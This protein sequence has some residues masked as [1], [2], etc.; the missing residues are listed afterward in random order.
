MSVLK[1]AFGKEGL[2]EAPSR[3]VANVDEA[4]AAVGID[5]E[6]RVLEIW[7]SS[8]G[9]VFGAALKDSINPY[10][11]AADIVACANE[12]ARMVGLET[13]DEKEI[14]RRSAIEFDRAL[15]RSEESFRNPAVRPT[16]EKCSKPTAVI[17][18]GVRYCKAH[19]REHGVLPTGKI[20]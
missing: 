11:L 4:Q 20:T 3:S 18:D 6:G 7:F 12:M 13:L 10:H 2:V 5:R 15:R 8:N 14:A 16:C 17:V 19:A 9:K 1:D